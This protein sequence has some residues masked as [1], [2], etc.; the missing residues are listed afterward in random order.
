MTY[1]QWLLMIVIGFFCLLFY[2]ILF[3]L[4][5][6]QKMNTDFPSFY[7]SASALLMNQ[8]P[9]GHLFGYFLKH[10]IDVSLNLNPPIFV[11]ACFPFALLSYPFALC[12]WF[13]LSLMMGI[14]AY[15]LSF[16]R[17]FPYYFK[18]YGLITC[19]LFLFFLPN[20]I[21]ICIAQV[22]HLL[23]FLIALGWFFLK[24]EKPIVAG[25][26]F[27]IVTSI[28]FFPGLLFFYAL[29]QKHYKTCYSMMATFGLLCLIPYYFYGNNLYQS[30]FHLFSDF[31]WWY[32]NSW[33]ASLYG[34]LYRIVVSPENP[35]FHFSM[36]IAH[37]LFIF[38][39]LIIIAGYLIIIN[40]LTGE[41][42]AVDE[43][44]MALTI[45]V[46]LFLSPFGWMDYLPMLI[47]PLFVVLKWFSTKSSIIWK[48]DIKWLITCLLINFP[49]AA[50]RTPLMPNFISKITYYSVYFYGLF[51][52]LWLMLKVVKEP[53]Y[54]GTMHYSKNDFF[55]Y[56]SV[57]FSICFGL[58]LFINGVIVALYR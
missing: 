24:K 26:S 23:F 38:L 34:F 58:I 32:G 28:K 27:G 48:D 5:A 39:F 20:L 49:I 44:K 47:I 40:R 36:T 53:L 46:M 52:L 55:S 1:K 43:K 14:A 2:G 4:V 8:Q 25:I 50:V 17:I 56:F 9:Y 22:G 37:Y 41:E 11:L 21:D 51:M 6:T 42:S 13:F 54:S 31:V 33:N 29:S 30:Y 7:G 12:S 35:P 45:V 18:S 3:F 16:Y 10:P 57:L 15:L 19:L